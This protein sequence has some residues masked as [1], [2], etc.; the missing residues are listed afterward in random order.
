[1][2]DPKASRRYRRFSGIVV[3]MVTASSGGD[4]RLA[5]RRRGAQPG[6]DVLERPVEED[7]SVVAQAAGEPG[8]CFGG[9]GAQ[10]REAGGGIAVELECGRLE[11]QAVP[12]E[13]CGELVGQR[14]VADLRGVQSVDGP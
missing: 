5:R 6:A 12:V 4:L 11:G 7:G 13:Q 3:V 1:M 14:P 2:T 8:Q 10:L 9:E